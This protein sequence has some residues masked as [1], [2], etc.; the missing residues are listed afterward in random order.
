VD[1]RERRGLALATAAAVAVAAGVFTVTGVAAVAGADCSATRDVLVTSLAAA[2]GTQ[3]DA[4][5]L[6]LTVVSRGCALPGSVGYAVRPVTTDRWDLTYRTGLLTFAEGDMK[7]QTLTVDVHAD[8]QIEPDEQFIVELIDL[9]GSLRA[10]DTMATV[11]IVNDDP[12]FVPPASPSPGIYP[13][14]LH[15]SR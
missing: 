4:T 1:V 11:T 5:Q 2:E 12:R 8:D 14:E 15:S 9:R 6:T 10:C 3:R 7:D 13:C